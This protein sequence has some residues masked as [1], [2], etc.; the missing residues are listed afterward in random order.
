MV[1]SESN[2]LCCVGRSRC[3]EPGKI[4]TPLVTTLLDKEKNGKPFI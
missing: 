3:S 2:V 1:G 4:G